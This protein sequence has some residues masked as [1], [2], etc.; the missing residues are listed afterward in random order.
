[1]KE[2]K[3]QYVVEAEQNAKDLAERMYE[4]IVEE[5]DYINIDRKWYLEKVIQYMRVE[6]E[7]KEDDI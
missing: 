6:I 7:K 1:M 5:A 4:Q 2:K 3:E